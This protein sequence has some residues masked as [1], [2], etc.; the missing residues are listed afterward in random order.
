M[1]PEKTVV[2]ATAEGVVAGVRKKHS[3]DPD[4]P[5]D[6]PW[7]HA[8][9]QVWS[10]E[11]TWAV[12]IVVSNPDYGKYVTSAIVPVGEAFHAAAVRQLYR[13]PAEEEHR[14]GSDAE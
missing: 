5:V 12:R 4:P 11:G 8:V 9:T 13:V 10:A 7:V 2:A 14:R 6:A 1:S 3:A